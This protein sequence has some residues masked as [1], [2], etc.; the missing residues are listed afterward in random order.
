MSDWVHVAAVIRID[1]W[2]MND[3]DEAEEVRNYFG[4]ECLWGGGA[5]DDYH[6]HPLDYLPMGSE[7]TLHIS[8]WTNPNINFIPAYT[9]TIFG[10]LRDRSSGQAII[11]WF[12]DKV[13]KLP[14]KWDTRQAVITTCGLDGVLTWAGDRYE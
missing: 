11:D 12:K 13:K 1:S 3:E 7:G 2:R 5:W 8:S 10:D 9:I 14:E 6:E 4:K